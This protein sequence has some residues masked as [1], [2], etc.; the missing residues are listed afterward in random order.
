M[1]AP[2]AAAAR[3]AIAGRMNIG[4]GS[5]PACDVAAA[6]TRL[7]VARRCSV[8]RDADGRPVTEDHVGGIA[9]H[10]TQLISQYGPWAVFA[11]VLVEDFGV[12][13]APGETA[14]VSAALLASRGS[15]SIVPLLIVAWVGAVLGDNIGYVFGRIAGRRLVLSRGARFGITE[16]RLM[17]VERFFEHY[18][19]VV[20]VF[21]R[22]VF[23]LRQIN[24]LVAGM[25]SVRAPAF[26]LYNAIGAGLW[27]GFWGLGAYGFGNT[28]LHILTGVG[29]IAIY[30]VLSLVVAGVVAGLYWRVR[31]KR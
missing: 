4:D 5:G 22:F 24:G 29:P 19:C 18:G 8:H 23:G 25:S 16:R 21:A 13:L 2:E 14:L 1:A 12:V 28:F 15:M 3:R 9:L 11:I 27:V 30:I 6:R 31:L 20:I 10:V 7:C 26:L 17:R